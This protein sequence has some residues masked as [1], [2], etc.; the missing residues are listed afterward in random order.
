VKIKRTIG[1]RHVTIHLSDAE[2][3]EAYY[4]Q[5]YWFDIES[6]REYAINFEPTL[7]I[8]QRIIDE[9]SRD[10]LWLGAVARELRKAMNKNGT[11]LEQ[12]LEDTV[13]EALLEGIVYHYRRG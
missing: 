3:L 12:Q 9:C 5:Q 10:I 8:P 4:E 7:A 11:S 13:K 6:V 2:R 1:G